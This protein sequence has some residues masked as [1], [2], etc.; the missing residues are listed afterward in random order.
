VAISQLL[1]LVIIGLTMLGG[2]GAA[3]AQVR[4]PPTNADR[5]VQQLIANLQSALNTG[6]VERWAAE[7]MPDAQFIVPNGDVLQ[8]RDQIHT[9]AAK[10]LR[11]VLK[12]AS[13]AIRIDRVVPLGTDYA[14]VD[15]THFVRS[16]REPPAWAVETKR[17]NWQHVA[18]YICQRTN[19]T[20]WQVVA[21]QFT[22]IRSTQQARR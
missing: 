1:R 16:L 3:A 18:R 9:D 10:V 15:T 14:I 20:D 17:G 12:G 21:L 13:T 8:G 19:D 5:T 2:G 22:P 4:L 7:F 6:N 11:G